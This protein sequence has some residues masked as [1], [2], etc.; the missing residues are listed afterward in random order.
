M[1]VRMSVPDW[2]RYSPPAIS[3]LVEKNSLFRIAGN[4]KLRLWKR[5]GILDL[6]HSTTPE[7]EEI[8]C[9]FPAKQGSVRREEFALDSLRR[10]T[11][12]KSRDFPLGSEDGSGKAREFAR[13]WRL[14]SFDSEAETGP[15]TGRSGRLARLSL[16]A[17]S[18]V[19]LGALVGARNSTR[20]FAS[21]FRGFAANQIGSSNPSRPATEPSAA[22]TIRIHRQMDREIPAIPTVFAVEVCRIRKTAPFQD[23]YTV[24]IRVE[25][26]EERRIDAGHFAFRPRIRVR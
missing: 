23:P 5:W 9:I 24:V 12:N 14:R 18:V 8:P 19:Q 2:R 13:C 15:I 3:L 10:H 4:S 26:S 22:E 11:V 16:W 20:K 6:I 7:T 25:R 1:V 17:V 21:W